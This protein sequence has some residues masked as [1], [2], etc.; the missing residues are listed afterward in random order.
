MSKI[1]IKAVIFDLGGVLVTTVDRHP[2]QKWEARLGLREGELPFR[3]LETPES[4]LAVEGKITEVDAWAY[5]ASN[6]ALTASEL[7]EFRQDYYAGDQLDPELTRFFCGLRPTYK[8]AILTNAWPGA[9][10]VFHR[11][12][13]LGIL[14]DQVIYS[15]EEGLSKPDLRIYRLCAKRL[16]VNICESVFIDD[17]PENVDAAHRAGMQGIL[18]KDTVKTLAELQKLLQ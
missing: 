18:F 1:S 10:H 12:F 6:F 13:A 4:A 7:R 16:R 3:V 15:A 2:Q 14:T 9:R 5:V 8:T 17:K 11:K